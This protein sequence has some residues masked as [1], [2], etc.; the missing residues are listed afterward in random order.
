MVS[1]CPP[2]YCYIVTYLCWP[3]LW[4][5]HWELTL[6]R[7]QVW[8]TRAPGIRNT[9]LQPATSS[10]WSHR[11][12]ESLLL[13]SSGR[14][15][16]PKRLSWFTFDDSSPNI[17]MFLFLIR[18]QTVGLALLLA[19]WP[20]YWPPPL[21][22]HSPTP[23]RRSKP[24]P[25]VTTAAHLHHSLPV[26]SSFHCHAVHHRV[27]KLT[28]PWSRLAWLPHPPSQWLSDQITFPPTKKYN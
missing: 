7:S 14:R 15:L 2:L 19:W 12:S 24:V 13:A 26:R 11:H 4:Q 6:S 9:T 5:F 3:C 23:G 22:S 18:C 28:I 27:Y 20:S 17:Y 1:C 25:D 8:I 21:H 16:R 10:Y